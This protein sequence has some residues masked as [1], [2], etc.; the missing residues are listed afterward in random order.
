MTCAVIIGCNVSCAAGV[1]ASVYMYGEG[2]VLVKVS[3]LLKLRVK[4]ALC[5]DYNINMT[6]R[7]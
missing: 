1:A 7:W 6:T 5:Q 2:A 3:V 4:S